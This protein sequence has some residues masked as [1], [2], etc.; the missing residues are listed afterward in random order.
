MAVLAIAAPV[1]IAAQTASPTPR[2]VR[3][4]METLHQLG[5][6]PPG[7]MLTP[8]SGDVG[9]GRELYG[10]LGCPT[11]HAVQ[12]EGFAAPT[13][14]GPDLTGMGGHHP[15]GYFAESVF[16]PNAVI[17]DGPGF[18]AADGRSTMPAYPDVT[19]GQL[20]DLVA[21]VASL[22]GGPHHSMAASVPPPASDAEL[23]PA[24]ASP[25]QRHL[26]QAYD[27]QPGRL[28]DFEQW[29]RSEGAA[30]MLAQPG[31]LGIE[32]WVDRSRGGPRIFTIIAFADEPSLFAFSSSHAGEQVGQRFDSFIGTHGHDVFNVPPLYRVDSLSARPTPA[33]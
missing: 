14:P 12:G 11:C 23:P 15:P 13:A 16:N 10:K 28:A 30:A 20:A 7:W 9:R 6:V 22:T 32:T 8:P 21:Y 27:V 3:I 4:T 17:V 26:V 24:P 25:A 31:V 19:L 1:G 33:R 18:F 5:G 2:L 29:F